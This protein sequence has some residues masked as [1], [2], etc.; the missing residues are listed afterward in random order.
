M[1]LDATRVQGLLFDIDGTLSDTDNAYVARLAQFLPAAF[2]VHRQRLARRLVMASERP[3]NLMFAL[4]DELQLE[5][6]LI[7]LLD[8]INRT[9]HTRP[10]PAYAPVPGVPELLASLHGRYPMAVV[11]A[12]GEQ[13][14]RH[15][16]D[17]HGLTGY[18]GAIATALTCKH[19]KPFPDPVIWAAEQLGLPPANCVM[20]GDTT[21]DIRAGKSAGAQTAGVLCGFGEENE[22]RRFGANVVLESTAELGKLLI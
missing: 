3:G 19:S 7:G 4:L 6:P 8:A 1:T 22:L 16:L 12:R 13:G 11:S 9:R 17:V 5:R 20:I 21:V 15:F 14:V 18:F 10:D 2:G